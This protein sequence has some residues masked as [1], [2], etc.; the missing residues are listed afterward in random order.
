VSYARQW[1]VA[2]LWTN[3]IEG[4]VHQLLLTRWEPSRGRIAAITLGLNLATHPALWFL[5]PVWGPRWAWWGVHE[6]LVALVEAALLARWLRARGE[7]SARA[8][9]GAVAV[10][11]NLVSAGVG[12]IVWG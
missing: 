4:A 12:L 1:L 9:A 6:A 7:P 2:F 3:L 5:A 11:A 10:S 8:L